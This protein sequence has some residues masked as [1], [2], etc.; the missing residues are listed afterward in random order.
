MRFARYSLLV[1]VIG[2]LA[3]ELTRVGWGQI[4]RSLP[5]D[6]LFYILFLVLYLSIPITEVFI[7]RVTWSFDA[8]RSIPVFLKK[9]VYN[10][11][12][13]GYAGEVYFF[14]WARSNLE[15]TTRYVAETIRDN[16]IISSVA[17]TAVAITLLSFFL[18]RGEIGITDMLGDNTIW[19][20]VLGAVV[21]AVLIPVWIRFRR[22]LFSMR[23][24]TAGV[25]FS[26]HTVRLLLGQAL[27]IGMW[28][29]VMPDV[30]LDVWFTYAAVS[31]ILSRIPFVPNQNLIFLGAGVEL[32]SRVNIST[33]EVAGMLLVMSVL[34]KILNAILFG[35][36]S[37]TGTDV[38]TE[39]EAGGAVDADAYTEADGPAAHEP[40]TIHHDS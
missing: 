31:I 12:V 28:V 15:H 35:V 30:P 9:R 2:Y 5:V 40:E 17:S 11:D 32:S 25:I 16:N 10:R 38:D 26:L 4:W 24:K 3:I 22:F 14:A 23:L 8:L 36:I 21:V 19:Y 18:T 34:D 33:A 1:G 6:P 37:A 39:T 13:L 27:Q 7:Y 20:I 29:V